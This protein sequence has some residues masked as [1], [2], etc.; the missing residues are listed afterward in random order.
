MSVHPAQS[1]RAFP[2]DLTIAEVCDEL[3]L[4]RPTVYNLIREGQLPAYRVGRGGRYRVT[5]ASL[6]HYKA[7]HS[8]AHARK[9]ADRD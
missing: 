3:R 6:E 8:V 9:E 4:S 5:V 1:T 2:R 7:T